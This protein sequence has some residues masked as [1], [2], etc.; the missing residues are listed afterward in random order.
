MGLGFMAVY[1]VWVYGV[2]EFAFM[3]FNA[4]GV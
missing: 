2:E 1:G 3:K 4:Y